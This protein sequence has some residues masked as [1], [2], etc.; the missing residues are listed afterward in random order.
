MPSLLQGV[1]YPCIFSLP[2]S[3]PVLWRGYYKP[4]T[5]PPARLF[6]PLAPTALLYAFRCCARHLP[7]RAFATFQRLRRYR[8]HFGIVMPGTS[9]QRGVACNRRSGDILYIR[10]RLYRARRAYARVGVRAYNAFCATRAFRCHLSPCCARR[11]RA[12]IL[13]C[14]LLWDIL[15][16]RRLRM[17][18][19][20]SAAPL[21]L[22]PLL[23]V[24][25][26]GAFVASGILPFTRSS[27]RLNLAELRLLLP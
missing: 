16:T 23:I 26:A 17:K 8:I 4:V 19:A 22:A 21:P 6:Q 27:S 5:R 3:L 25:L 10:M 14:L 24:L 15:K 11:R 2:L 13:L 7:A 1:V 20:R 18:A 9:S 12:C